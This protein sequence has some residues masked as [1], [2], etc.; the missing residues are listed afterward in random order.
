MPDPVSPAPPSYRCVH[1][2]GSASSSTGVHANVQHSNA[3]SAVRFSPDGRHI[4]SASADKSV[5]IW[6]TYKNVLHKVCAGHEHGINDVAWS[7]DGRYLVSGSD[8]GTVRLYDVQTGKQVSK[9]YQG[10]LNYVFS[11]NFHPQTEIF[12]SGSFDESVRLWDARSGKCIKAIP[13]HSDA[14]TAVEFHP[15]GSFLATAS[16]DGLLRFWDPASGQC[17]KT[18][19]EETT[20]PVSGMRFSPNGG[21]L[22]T[23]SQ[24]AIVRLW[25]WAHTPAKR[26]KRYVGHDNSTKM[27][28]SPLFITTS[29]RQLVTC[30]SE[31]GKPVIWDLNSRAPVQRLDARDSHHP[32]SALPDSDRGGSAADAVPLAHSGRVLAMDAHPRRDIIVTGGADDNSIK[33]WADDSLGNGFPAR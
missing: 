10:H 25:D 26:L 16:Y 32:G 11:L 20:P 14:V 24:D 7:P 15:D 19:Q 8:D 12:A 4:A 29:G 23:S 21:Y 22:L 13:A 30:G 6:D 3:V 17:L 27:A 9:P 28:L 1:D 2:V 31:D 33:L 5:R 18:I